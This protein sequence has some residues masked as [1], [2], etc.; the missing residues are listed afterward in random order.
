LKSE[1]EEEIKRLINPKQL[2]TGDIQNL[3]CASA[4][5][6]E[7]GFLWDCIKKKFKV[8]YLDDI[9][10]VDLGV[11]PISQHYLMFRRGQNTAKRGGSLI[12]CI[13]RSLLR[14]QPFYIM[15]FLYERR[16]HARE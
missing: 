15:G 7:D 14:V 12:I 8:R 10:A 1:P 2:F 4:I 9:G 5:T 11:A 13:G 3:K 6:G 16:M